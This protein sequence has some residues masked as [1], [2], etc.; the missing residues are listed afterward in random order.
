MAPTIMYKFIERGWTLVSNPHFSDTS[1]QPVT[2]LLGKSPTQ[3][4]QKPIAP[5][6]NAIN[7]VPM[8]SVVILNGLGKYLWAPVIHWLNETAFAV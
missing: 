4:L 3:I 6:R 5:K 2:E 7:W 1:L 8:L